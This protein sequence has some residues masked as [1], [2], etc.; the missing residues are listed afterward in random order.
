MFGTAARCW[1]QLTN[2][3]FHVFSYS[4][5]KKIRA[6][7]ARSLGFKLLH[8]SPMVP[9]PVLMVYPAENSAFQRGVV[10]LAEFL[11]WHGG[12]SVAVDMWQQ[13]KIAELGPMR[14]LAEQAKAADRVLIVCPQVETVSFL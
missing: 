7:F 13:G 10:A 9:V 4:P 1:R 3:S 11:Q 12:C 2:T 5:D 14:W 6:N 8:A